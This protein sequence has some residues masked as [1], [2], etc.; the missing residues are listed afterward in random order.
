MN[1]SGQNI[2]LSH[3][4]DYSFNIS[5]TSSGQRTFVLSVYGDNLK[6]YETNLKYSFI[7]KTVC[8]ICGKDLDICKG[9]HTHSTDKVQTCP[10]CGKD[11]N[12]CPVNGDHS[13]VIY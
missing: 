5:P 8:S 1:E 4:D 10:T 3:H 9:K 12:D 2:P 13:K 11:I 7:K 6:L